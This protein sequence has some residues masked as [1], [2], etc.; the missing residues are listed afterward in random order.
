MAAARNMCLAF[1][2]IAITNEP[3]QLL[4]LSLASV[5]QFWTFASYFLV[6]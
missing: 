2:L 5:V 6:P 4:L 1:S 3:L